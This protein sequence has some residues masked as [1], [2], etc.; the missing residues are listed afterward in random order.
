M[1]FKYRSAGMAKIQQ[2]SPI[3]PTRTRELVKKVIER[4][5]AREPLV[6]PRDPGNNPFPK[7]NPNR[8]DP[9]VSRECD[10]S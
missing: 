1:R 3:D 5:N 10:D 2:P 8:P 4:A 9:P 7:Q 6:V